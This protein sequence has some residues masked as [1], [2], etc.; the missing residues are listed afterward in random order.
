MSCNPDYGI[1]A[2]YL[3]SIV[4]MCPG[5][6]TSIATLKM[7]GLDQRRKSKNRQDL[8]NIENTHNSALQTHVI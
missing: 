5:V 7:I 8:A 3:P 1:L 4:F 6:T 2:L